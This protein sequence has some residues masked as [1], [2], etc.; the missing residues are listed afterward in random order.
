MT[1]ILQFAGAK[2]RLFFHSAK[3]FHYK[4]LTISNFS[5]ILLNKHLISAKH[6]PLKP[7]KA[8]YEF[9]RLNNSKNIT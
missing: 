7:Y 1:T 4:L 3:F 5:C 6:I 8:V 2:L 9:L